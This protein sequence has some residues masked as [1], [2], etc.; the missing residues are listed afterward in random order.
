VALIRSLLNPRIDFVLGILF[1]SEANKDLLI[2]LINSVV[3][4]HLHIVDVVIKNPFNLANYRGSKETILDIKA[5][6]QDGTWYD[7]EMQTLAH[8]FYGKRAIYYA[9]KVYV[10]RLAA[11]DDYSSL[12]PTIGIHFLD[13]NYF[14][15]DRMVRQFVFKDMETNDHPEE[16]RFLQ[17]YFIEMRKF[18]K[19]W[20]QISTALDR[21]VAFLTRA[22]RLKRNALPAALRDEPAIVKA[23]AELERMGA[24]PEQREIYE[25]EVEA[26]MVDALQIKTAEERGMQLGIQRERNLIVRLMTR[27]IGQVPPVIATRVETLTPDQLDD[28]GGALLD[29][30]SYADVEAWLSRQ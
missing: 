13:F 15:D 24:D 28:L 5:M 27:H 11:A 3:G 7:I 22:E 29:L 19:D 17:L 20:P 8:V 23:V 10:D 26:R 12:N 14:D 16:L 9:A 1:G 30:N 4:P 6:D 25:M 18:R 21:W 2:S